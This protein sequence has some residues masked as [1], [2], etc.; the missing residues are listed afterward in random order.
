MNND[1]LNTNNLNQP[2][3]IR[4]IVD[5]VDALDKNEQEEVLDFVKQKRKIKTCL[6][7]DE[8]LSKAEKF[9]TENEIADIVSKDRKERYEQSLS[10]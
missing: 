8:K 7:L 9:V 5:E 4:Q 3:I 2:S 6:L 1:N 10:H